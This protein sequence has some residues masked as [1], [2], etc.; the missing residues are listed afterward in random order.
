[1]YFDT[2]VDSMYGGKKIQDDGETLESDWSQQISG[3][4]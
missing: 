3:Q 1:M 4:D 2:K